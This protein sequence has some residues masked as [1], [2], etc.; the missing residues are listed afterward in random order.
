[1]D[2]RTERL[3]QA[4]QLASEALALYMALSDAA[5]KGNVRA[6]R[7]RQLAAERHDRRLYVCATLE[8]GCVRP[9]TLAEI[10]AWVLCNWNRYAGQ[11]GPS[12][13]AVA[14]GASRAFGIQDEDNAAPEWLCGAVGRIVG[15]EE[16]QRM[17]RMAFFVE[18]PIRYEPDG[19]V[20]WA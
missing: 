9:V 6:E 4:Q 18:K 13:T 7:L 11:F 19:D 16:L 14:V 8:E 3:A 10:R 1:M 20:I 17:K 5:A 15:R 2:A 12:V